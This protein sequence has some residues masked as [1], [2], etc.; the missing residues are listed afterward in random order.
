MVLAVTGAL[1]ARVSSSGSASMGLYASAQAQGAG[2]LHGQ[3]GLYFAATINNRDAD[4][5]V[6]VAPRPHDP[7]GAA[8]RYKDDLGQASRPREGLLYAT[9]DAE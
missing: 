8:E 5:G 1:L 3:A 9:R 7:L 4:P 2:S 6:L